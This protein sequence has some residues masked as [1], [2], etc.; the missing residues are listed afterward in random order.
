M[1]Y[2]PCFLP[3]F[4]QDLSI[5]L[6]LNKHISEQQQNLFS[7]ASHDFMSHGLSS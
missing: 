4:K 2:S 6:V 7:L 1:Q 5:F 3:P